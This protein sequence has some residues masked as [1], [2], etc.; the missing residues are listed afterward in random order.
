MMF[1][2]SAHPLASFLAGF[3]CGALTVIVVL[4]YVATA[5]AALFTDTKSSK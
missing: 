5:G 3:V 2:L 1:W 4:I